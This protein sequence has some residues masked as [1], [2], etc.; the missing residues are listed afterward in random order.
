MGG[1]GRNDIPGR[2]KFISII[3]KYRTPGNN[4]L[5]NVYIVPCKYTRSHGLVG[6]LVEMFDG[7]TWTTAV[8]LKDVY[9]LYKEG[10]IA[11]INMSLLQEGVDIWTPDLSTRWIIM[12]HKNIKYPPLVNINQAISDNIIYETK[13]IRA[14]YNLF[15][16]N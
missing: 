13:E 6:A 12:L 3:E 9:K 2:D 11:V 10:K 1:L 4:R 16:F 5:A 14:R 8:R 15:N 7:A